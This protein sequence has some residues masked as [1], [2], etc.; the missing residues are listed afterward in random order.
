MLK[1]I[2]KGDKMTIQ[3]FSSLCQRVGHSDEFYFL[4]GALFLFTLSVLVKETK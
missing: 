3:E 1:T 4:C 2:I